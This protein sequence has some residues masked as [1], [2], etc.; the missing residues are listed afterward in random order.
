LARLVSAAR[1]LLAEEG[2]DGV[3]VHAVVARANASVGS[4]Y[5]RFVGKED[6]IRYVQE[7]VWGDVSRWWDGALASAEWE[8]LSLEGSVQRAI[9][10]LGDSLAVLE[11]ERRAL[12]SRQEGAEAEDT[13]YQRV[14]VSLRDR[15]M[16]NRAEIRHPHPDRAVELG[17]RAVLGILRGLGS[18]GAGRSGGD[19][20]WSPLELE[21][22]LERLFL[23]YVGGR[24]G[25][26]AD[27]AK[28]G[29]VD[30]FDVWG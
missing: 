9:Q 15:L 2:V 3:T 20:G 16:V 5:A 24:P 6:L 30:F 28:P 8:G 1:E 29:K 21:Q 13:F 4:F 17:L 23:A 27:D 12:R 11:P 19:A 10:A 7:E 18:E 25:Q 26:P 22:E 14:R